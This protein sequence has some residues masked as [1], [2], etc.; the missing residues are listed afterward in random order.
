LPL[1]KKEKVLEIAMKLSGK[2]GVLKGWRVV[3][4][5]LPRRERRHTS[6]F[7]NFWG[8]I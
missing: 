2:T 5:E 4:A 1:E 7:A 6:C 3:V 8:S